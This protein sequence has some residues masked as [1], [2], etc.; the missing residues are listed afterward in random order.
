L[1]TVIEESMGDGEMKKHEKI[2]AVEGIDTD[3]LP[4]SKKNKHIVKAIIVC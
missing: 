3:I 4:G 2:A 1:A